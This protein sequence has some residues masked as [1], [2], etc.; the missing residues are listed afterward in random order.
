MKGE[1]LYL[2]LSFKS[3][4]EILQNNGIYH[5]FRIQLRSCLWSKKKKKKKTFKN[6]FKLFN[7]PPPNFFKRLRSASFF[8]RIATAPNMK[9]FPTMLFSD[10]QTAFKHFL[11]NMAAVM[12]VCMPINLIRSTFPIFKASCVSCSNHRCE[13]F[14][15]NMQ[16]CSVTETARKQERSCYKLQ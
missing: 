14:P 3:E 8:W 1:L 2:T 4:V 12:F 10:V 11:E 5:L 15:L 13:L 9:Y 16:P 7:S 6:I